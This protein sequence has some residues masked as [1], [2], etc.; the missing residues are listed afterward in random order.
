MI[1]LKT[2]L[3]YLNSFIYN[4]PLFNISWK[5]MP[6]IFVTDLQKSRSLRFFGKKFSLGS[7]TVFVSIWYTVGNRGYIREPIR[8][9]IPVVG[10]GWSS[11]RKI[12]VKLH[13]I[14]I[15]FI[16]CLWPPW[17]LRIQ[18]LKVNPN[19]NV[20]FEL[21]YP[22][23]LIVHR[24]FDLLTFAGVYFYWFALSIILDNFLS[25][26]HALPFPSKNKEG[27]SCNCK[28][29]I[30]QYGIPILSYCISHIFFRFLEI[31]MLR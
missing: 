8:A 1:Y 19:T 26:Y 4:P 16:P 17:K 27:S 13:W 18:W 29:W 24:R 3:N 15:L 7:V 5:I 21:F 30:F 12:K 31:Q 23:N 9:P 28:M 22:G 20:Q 25:F 14:H 6:K 11:G 2:I 10:D